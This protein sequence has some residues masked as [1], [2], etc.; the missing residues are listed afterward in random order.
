[1]PIPQYEDET[2]TSVSSSD[3][4]DKTNNVAILDLEYGE[5]LLHKGRAPT[6]PPAW[7]LNAALPPSW[8]ELSEYTKY[9]KQRNNE[10]LRFYGGV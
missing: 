10:I 3:Q 6:H 1:M 9:P 8:T 7:S 2:D 5:Y 4:A